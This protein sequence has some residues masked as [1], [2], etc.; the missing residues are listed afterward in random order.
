MSATASQLTTRLRTWVL[1]AGLTALTIAIRAV[2][3][4]TFPRAFVAFAIG[5][6][7]ST[8]RLSGP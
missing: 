1:V 5:R 8:A 4:G 2:L 6:T 7:A 3:G